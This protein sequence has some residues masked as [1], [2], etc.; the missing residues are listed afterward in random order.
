VFILLNTEA[1]YYPIC[2]FL[3]EIP[4]FLRNYYELASLA[5]NIKSCISYKNINKGLISYRHS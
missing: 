1:A 2:M 3:S 5:A 4:I